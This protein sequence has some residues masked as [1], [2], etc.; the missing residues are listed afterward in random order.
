MN[1]K[2]PLLDSLES[3]LNDIASEWNGDNPGLQEERAT[4][5][6]DAIEKIKEL[7]LLLEELEI[8]Y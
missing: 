2:T 6:L 7:K 5:S 8:N 1:N 3:E 4:A